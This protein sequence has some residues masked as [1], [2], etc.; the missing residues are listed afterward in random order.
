MDYNIATT[1]KIRQQ[2][3]LM[4]IKIIMILPKM[5]DYLALSSSPDIIKIRQQ[6][7]LSQSL[8]MMKLIT[9][10]KSSDDICVGLVIPGLHLG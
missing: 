1:V 7:T 5:M 6:E 3:Y 8:T 4:M 9:M 10:I 2:E